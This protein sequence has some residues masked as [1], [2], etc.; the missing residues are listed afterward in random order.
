MKAA[1]R[2]HADYWMLSR[3]YRNRSASTRCADW[4]ADDQQCRIHPII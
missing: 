4:P 2:L 1:C 3:H